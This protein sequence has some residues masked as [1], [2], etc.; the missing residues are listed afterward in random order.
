L[1]AH[2]HIYDAAQRLLEITSAMTE[3]L[4]QN[5][6]IV[7]RL[8]GQFFQHIIGEYVQSLPSE[9]MDKCVSELRTMGDEA[10]SAMKHDE[11]LSAYATILLLTPSPPEGVLTARS[12]LNE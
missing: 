9:F 6:L 3:N 12:L 4:K 1:Y 11:A 10:S 7:D 8:K 2:G 5:K